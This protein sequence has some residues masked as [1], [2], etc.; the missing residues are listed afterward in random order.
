MTT[1][2]TF[3]PK[4]ENIVANLSLYNPINSV[5]NIPASIDIGLEKPILLKCSDYKMTILRFNAPLNNISPT[6]N[7]EG[8]N[9]SARFRWSTFTLVRTISGSNINFSI[10]SF[11]GAINQLFQL[12]TNDLFSASGNNNDFNP[13]FPPYIM[14]D[15]KTGIFYF[16]VRYTYVNN[17]VLID[18]SKDLQFF[19]SG[20]PLILLSDGFY[21]FAL[22]SY[23]NDDYQYF[24]PRYNNLSP[25]A[26]V[27][28][29]SPTQFNSYKLISEFNTD[30][31]FNFLQSIVIL[32]N[33][34]IRQETLPLSTE[35]AIKD[36]SNPFSYIATLPI[37]NDFRGLI[38]RYGQ[39]VSN[40][41]YTN[42]GEFR[43]MDLLSDKPLDRLSFDFRWQ[44]TD[45]QLHQLMLSPGESISIKIYFKSMK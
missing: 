35:N 18:I 9:F 33:I 6:F 11:I 3:Q 10:S 39:Q 43:W 14:M 21:S 13:M 28:G 45:Q 32:S 36:P 44:S 8:K 42:Q 15:E 4:G 7:M 34:P 17:N 2:Y 37:L 19:I 25:S 29:N 12:L 31:R 38:E 24:S 23:L 22:R 40:L 27:V 30:Y 41:L 1:F 26:S 20:F 16:V 5:S